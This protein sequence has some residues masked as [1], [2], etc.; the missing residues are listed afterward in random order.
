MPTHD[1][2]SLKSLNCAN[3]TN[4]LNCPDK[5]AELELG[6]IKLTHPAFPPWTAH[7]EFAHQTQP[8][9]RVSRLPTDIWW[10]PTVVAAYLR[11]CGD[12]VL[13]APA[14]L[15]IDLYKI[16]CASIQISLFRSEETIK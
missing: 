11:V 16:S 7:S 2:L 13:I 9:I 12:Q 15:S 4:Q 5:S 6:S 3:K 10:W 1:Q 14:S 8:L